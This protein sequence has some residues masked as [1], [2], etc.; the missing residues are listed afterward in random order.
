M[1]SDPTGKNNCGVEPSLWLTMTKAEKQRAYSRA[2]TARRGKTR[3][4]E[5]IAKQNRSYLERNRDK[6]NASRK[7][8]RAENKEKVAA[9]RKAYREKNPE[10]AAEAQRRSKAKRKAQIA[11]YQKEYRKRYKAKRQ[12]IA[13]HIGELRKA[14]LMK[15]DI[16]AAASRAVPAY[17][18]R[19]I[20]DDVISDIVLGTLEGAI[21]AESIQTK[22]KEFV[23]AHLRNFVDLKTVSLDATIPGADGLTYLDRLADTAMEYAE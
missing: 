6:I 13:G 7:L 21:A 1:R 23:R 15:N 14:E 8:W 19:W 16:Y 2:S 11:A 5:Q 17:L 9:R 12:Q 22:A 4:K 10:A 18:P 20:R 3:T